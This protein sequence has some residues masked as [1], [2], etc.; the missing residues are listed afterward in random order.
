M[1]RELFD[2]WVKDGSIYECYPWDGPNPP[3]P[4]LP[5]LTRVYAS[6]WN[7]ERNEYSKSG[8]ITEYISDPNIHANIRQFS[9]LYWPSKPEEMEIKVNVRVD[10]KNK[11]KII[12]Y[13][14]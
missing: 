14:R 6:L 7:S 2:K 9:Y 11:Y 8:E 12:D 1:Q 13:A 5:E 10:I 4:I 3:G